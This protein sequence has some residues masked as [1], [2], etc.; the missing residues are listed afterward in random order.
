MKSRAYDG[1]A[2]ADVRR[3]SGRREWPDLSPSRLFDQRPSPR[4]HTDLLTG[5]RYELR[6]LPCRVGEPAAQRFELSREGEP[7]SIVSDLVD[8]HECNCLGF[9]RSWDCPHARIV[10]A[11]GY[12]AE[13]RFALSPDTRSKGVGHARR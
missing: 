13:A 2:R 1:A 5:Q 4:I 9:R 11:L 12:V 6:Q 10:V 8:Y 3:P 7:P